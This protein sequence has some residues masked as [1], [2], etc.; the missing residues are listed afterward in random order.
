MSVCSGPA[1]G[2]DQ[3]Y[4][5]AF[6]AFDED[7]DGVIPAELLGKLLRACGFITSPEDLDAMLEDLRGEDLTFDAFRNIVHYYGRAYDPVQEFANAFHLWDLQGTGKIKVDTVNDILHSFKH[8]LS[9]EE[10]RDL[11]GQADVDDDGFLDY[12]DLSRQLLNF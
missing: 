4:R 7:E 2:R 8:P 9:E 12:E 6:N 10:I 1:K 3:G 11:L 5:N